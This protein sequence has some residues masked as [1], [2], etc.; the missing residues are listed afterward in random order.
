[1]VTWQIANGI[2]MRVLPKVLI[3]LGSSTLPFIE[4]DTVPPGCEHMYNLEEHG[5]CQ[6]RHFAS[7]PSPKLIYAS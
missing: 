7:L 2:L 6:L 5:S 4:R 3:G 1:M